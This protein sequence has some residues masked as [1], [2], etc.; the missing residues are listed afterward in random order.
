MS[1]LFLRR[2]GN[3]VRSQYSLVCCMTCCS[4]VQPPVHDGDAGDERALPPPDQANLH[5]P[6]QGGPGPG[7]H[8][9]C[10]YTQ[11]NQMLYN[12]RS[13]EINVEHFIS[14]CLIGWIIPIVLVTGL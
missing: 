11:E 13:K 12:I 2:Q 10:R 9:G 4:R 1:R 3:G 14:S 8:Q 5:Q 7:H 6:Q